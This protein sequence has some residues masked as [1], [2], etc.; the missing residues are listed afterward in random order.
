MSA[1]VTVGAAVGQNPSVYPC[2]VSVNGGAEQAISVVVSAAAL[3]IIPDPEQP[4]YVQ[5]RAMLGVGDAA[6]ATST[7]TP[8]AT[9]DPAP[10]WAQNWITGQI[11]S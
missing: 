6:D 10:N 1:V 7:V 2:Q 5:A 11:P 4:V 3:A 9:T 8:Y